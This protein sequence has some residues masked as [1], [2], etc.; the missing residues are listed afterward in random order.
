MTA[1][2]KRRDWIIGLSVIGGT[3]FLIILLIFAVSMRGTE[4]QSLRMSSSSGSKIAVITLDGPIYN[5]EPVVRQFKR[6]GEDMSIKALIFRINSPG[7]GVAASQDIYEAARR[8]RESGKPVIA[9]MGT[10]AASGG[11]Y[12]ALGADTIIAN[13]GTTTGSIGVIA[14]FLDMTDLFEKIGIRSNVLKSGRFKDSGSPYR[15]MTDMDRKYLQSWIDD[16]YEQF[17]GA[18]AS[19]R[20]MSPGQLYELADGR[21]F[22]GKQAAENGLI[23]LLGD[24]ETAIKTAAE[25]AGIKGEPSLVQIRQKEATLFDLLL[26]NISNMLYGA[27]GMV[28]QYRFL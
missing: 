16:A 5:S 20:E 15:H 17:K 22:T 19:E 1:S 24:F 14:Q 26:N 18:V 27:N 10:I 6:F 11:Y 23:D 8:V 2:K 28:L 7:G 4:Y 12:A 21:V 9:H 13:P 3:F 25:M